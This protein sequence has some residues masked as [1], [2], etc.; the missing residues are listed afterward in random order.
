[1]MTAKQESYIKSLFSKKEYEVT[2]DVAY[3]TQTNNQM[4]SAS[5]AS[6]VI[7]YLVSCPDKKVVESNEAAK[8]IVANKKK[9]VNALNN[10]K[11]QEFGIELR[12]AGVKFTYTNQYLYFLTED[13]KVEPLQASAEQAGL[14]I[15]IAKKHVRGLK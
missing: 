8:L 7:E 1:M 15:E 3:Y 6:A 9:I 4:I 5:E 2:P 13:G 10:K 12:K 11:K 14:F